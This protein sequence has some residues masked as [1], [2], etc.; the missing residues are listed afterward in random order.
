MDVTDDA[1]M[2]EA[3]GHEVRIFPGSDDNI[4]VTTPSDVVVAEALLAARLA[5]SGAAS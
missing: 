5:P 4:K 2:V 1:A 3:L